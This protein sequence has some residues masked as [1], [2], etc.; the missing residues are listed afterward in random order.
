MAEH[1]WDLDRGLEVWRVGP[2]LAL[3]LRYS[4]ATRA[5]NWACLFLVEKPFSARAYEPFADG[6]TTSHIQ[7][8]PRL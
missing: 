2:A 1:F 8:D 4:Y 3:E 7:I 6:R 5:E